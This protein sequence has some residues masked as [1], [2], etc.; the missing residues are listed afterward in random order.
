MYAQILGRARDRNAL[1]CG[2]FGSTLASREGSSRIR[3]RA[4]R[5][6]L[7]SLSTSVVLK[8]GGCGNRSASVG[9][10]TP[11][12]ITGRPRVKSNCAL[13]SRPIM[14]CSRATR[15]ASVRSSSRT[16]AG[17]S[18]RAPLLLLNACGFVILVVVPGVCGISDDKRPVDS[19]HA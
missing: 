6:L 17:P 19:S 7:T 8:F 15:S 2:E 4:S 18:F 5:T 3:F 10:M 13:R 1:A 16:G 14:A 9:A 12:G 11:G